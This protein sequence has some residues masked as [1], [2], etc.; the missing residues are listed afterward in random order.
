MEMLHFTLYLLLFYIE[1]LFFFL[2][3]SYFGVYI[4]ITFSTFNRLC[5]VKTN[6]INNINEHQEGKS[7][8]ILSLCPDEISHYPECHLRHAQNAHP[9][10]QAQNP[11]F[12]CVQVRRK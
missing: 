10:E 4:V 6:Q 3:S 2:I 11:S 1:F 7:K 8:L 9:C 5:S 12:K